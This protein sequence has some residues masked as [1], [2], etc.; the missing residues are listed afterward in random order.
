MPQKPAPKAKLPIDELDYEKGGRA[1]AA[2]QALLDEQ[3]RLRRKRRRKI[4]AIVSAAFLV[5]AYLALTTFVFDPLEGSAIAFQNLVP[6]NCD[7]LVRKTDLADDLPLPKTV[8]TP[9]G[10]DAPVW[11]AFVEGKLGVPAATV[12]SGLDAW[13]EI[14]KSVAGSSL[15]LV[16]DAVGQE[17][18]FAGRFAEKG[19]FAKTQM[20]LYLRVGWR[21]R[22]GL[23]LARYSYF[24]GLL[25]SGVGLD[26]KDGGVFKVSQGGRDWYLWR[27][28]DLLLAASD[29]AWIAEAKAL[30]LDKGKGSFGQGATFT[31]DIQ[32]LLKTRQGDRS[33]MPSN[34]QLYCNVQA[35]RKASG[36]AGAW[37]DPQ[38]ALMEDRAI[39]SVFRSNIVHEATGI[40]RFEND[41]RRRIVLDMSFRTDTNDLDE[42]GKRVHQ[43]RAT[44]KL[45][46]KDVLLAADMSPKSA[47]AFGGVALS[48]GDLARQW[49]A[50]LTQ[51]DRRTMDEVLR[52]TVKYQTL[53]AFMD[54][55]GIALGQRALVVLRENNY[56][57]EEK[58]PLGDGPEPAMAFVFPQQG[59]EKVRQ[60]KEYLLVNSGALGFEQTFNYYVDANKQYPLLE[61]Y[62]PMS[63]STGE[64]AVMQIGGDERGEVMITNQAKLAK[65]IFRTWLD[66]SGG[67][68]DR[69]YSTDPLYKDLTAEWMEYKGNVFSHVFGF[70]NGPQL[71]KALRKYVPYWAAEGSL[72]DPEKMRLERPAMF[73]RILKEK[74]P[75]YTVHNV[76]AKERAEIDELV[77]AE[78]SAKAEAAKAKIS[79]QLTKQYMEAIAWI[80]AVPGALVSVDLDPKSVKVYL[81]VALE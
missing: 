77:D 40:V 46:R 12:K 35:M 16:R 33:R 67:T 15:N 68:L 81:N 18:C 10:E 6:R 58:D 78:W 76:P 34:V 52:K 29:E 37:P 73:S 14:E 13:A 30:V 45:T 65:N 70:V 8:L 50:L 47:F 36:A 69:P 54:D 72:F 62:T 61:Y 3:K 5:I 74:Y 32:M 26:V 63:R 80:A 4:A 11:N 20:G 49:E 27:S 48:G 31:D 38:S 42:F 1:G 57:R 79:P 66:S 2:M 22:L 44:R 55:V 71:E 25:F 39:A 41:P 64:F 23:G 28:G 19:G 24:R 59:P 43:E 9:M 7:F 75:Q 60:L 21:V 56:P 51:D 17:I 53:R